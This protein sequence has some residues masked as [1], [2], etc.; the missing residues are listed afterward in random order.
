MKE[1]IEEAIKDNGEQIKKAAMDAL[2]ER[3]V[4]QLTWSL[5][6]VI[7]PVVKT[8]FTDELEAEIATALMESKPVIMDQLRS[9]IV[10]CAAEIGV[11]M[12]EILVKNLTG[13]RGNDIIKRM[14]E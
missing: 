8:F 4:S 3:I 9:H 1:F 2:K 5:G 6:D 13:Y 14:F 11:K 12:Q 10:T 7:T